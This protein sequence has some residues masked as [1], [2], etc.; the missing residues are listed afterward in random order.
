MGEGKTKLMTLL[1]KLKKYDRIAYLTHRISLTKNASGLM[2]LDYYNDLAYGE[3]TDGVALCAN[4]LLKYK[5][6]TGGFNVL[7]LDEF[8]QIL[9]HLLDGTVENRQAVFDGFCAAIA[10][11]DFVVCSDA[12]LN[13]RC[14]EFLNRHCG[15]K[16]INL[17]EVEKPETNGRIYHFLKEDN[18]KSMC[19]RILRELQAGK[20]PFVG[21][22]TKKESKRLHKFLIE[23]GI[24][25]EKLLLIHS[26][27]RGDVKQSRFL[28][29]P[30]AEA[31]NYA[32]VIHSPTVGSGVSIEVACFDNVY[33]LHSGNITS[34]EAFQMTA[35]YRNAKH[36]YIAFGIQQER[37]RMTDED[38]LHEG[39]GKIVEHY[40]DHKGGS[41]ELGKARLA[42]HAEKNADKND[43][44]NNFALLVEL[45]GGVIDYDLI[46]ETL[47]KE[48][49][50][51]LK[52]LAQRAKKADVT[53]IK[54]ATDMSDNEF[55]AQK[56]V[57]PT[58][59]Q[60]HRRYRYLT[61]KMTGLSY[62]NV[63][64][65]DVEN[66]IND[67]FK[68]VVNLENLQA[69]VL[70]CQEWDRE[71]ALTQNKAKS[72]TSVKMLIAPMIDRLLAE[73][74]IDVTV[75]LREC[76]YLQQHAA[77]LAANGIGN[78]TRIGSR[79]VTTL[80]NLMRQF[81]YKIDFL[82]MPRKDGKRIREY[83]LQEIE[84]IHRYVTN[85]RFAGLSS[86]VR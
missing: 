48:E 55:E 16:K 79:P 45:K 64:E 65:F 77:E 38:I 54:A 2:E 22:T 72:K 84:H 8:R 81:G 36:I 85:R 26:D 46:D 75:A 73:E 57:A 23:Q 82:Q 7:F 56:N 43:F 83:K 47:T 35:R 15:G 60:S 59:E 30:N 63:T 39:F 76:E 10:A 1:R 32:C 67:D 40:T 86:V 66:F 29:N 5:L 9:D 50:A 74:V 6:E 20:K 42:L 25:E 34:N 13:D 52:G 4:S 12:D 62:D 70:A 31:D 69:N 27:N 33:L 14:I 71:N 53:D 24:P 58:Q 49:T 19:I 3:G 51:A 44:Q 37:N 61:K 21:C 68:R 80:A 28:D 18:F 41:N 11:A 78:Y 17:I